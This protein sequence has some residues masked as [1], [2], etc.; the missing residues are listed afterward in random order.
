MFSMQ[1]LYFCIIFIL[2]LADVHLFP[3][4]SEMT[5][6][7]GRGTTSGESSEETKTEDGYGM[8]T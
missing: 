1:D 4:L 7:G 3:Y 8:L 6:A 2:P 5:L